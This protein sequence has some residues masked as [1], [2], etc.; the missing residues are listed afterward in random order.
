MC[1]ACP[2]ELEG[3]SGSIF[4]WPRLQAVPGP[5]HLSGVRG[6]LGAVLL[7]HGAPWRL[8]EVKEGTVGCWF[9]TV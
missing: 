1:G 6:R 4:S 5:Q 3:L 8:H 2:A 7:H 9:G